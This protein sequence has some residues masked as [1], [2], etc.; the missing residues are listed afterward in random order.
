MVIDV[1]EFG[2]VMDRL[3][4]MSMLISVADAGS[5]SDYIRDKLKAANKTENDRQR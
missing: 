3:E 4:S 1:P 5:L 2:R